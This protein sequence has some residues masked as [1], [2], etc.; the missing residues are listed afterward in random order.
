M[1]NFTNSSAEKWFWISRKIN[2]IITFWHTQPINFIDERSKTTDDAI[3]KPHRSE[4]L[5]IETLMDEIQ[6]VV[7]EKSEIIVIVRCNSF[8]P[9]LENITQITKENLQCLRNSF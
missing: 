1:K 3:E 6:P 4:N 5:S 9:Y 7:L 8:I 2:N